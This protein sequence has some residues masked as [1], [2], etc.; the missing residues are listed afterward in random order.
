MPFQ[1]Q[2]Q[3]LPRICIGKIASAHGVKGLVK[4]MPFTHEHHLLHKVYTDETSAKTLELIIKN[5]L[6]KYLLAEIKGITDRTSAE[7]LGK[8][9]FYIERDAAAKADPK[10]SLIGLSALSA[11][12]TPIGIV[13][14]VEN[15]GAGDLLEIRLN[16]GKTVLVPLNDDFVPHIGKTITVINYEVFL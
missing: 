13:C 8:C 2:D 16:T 7:A 1:D 15:Y 14:S 3:P 6:G 12:G 5:P 4:I 11:D 9:S 10:I